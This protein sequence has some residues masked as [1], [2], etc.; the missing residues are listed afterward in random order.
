MSGSDNKESVDIQIGGGVTGNSDDDC[1]QVFE[2]PCVAPGRVERHLSPL[3]FAAATR[4]SNVAVDPEDD[5][6]WMVERSVGAVHKTGIVIEKQWFWSPRLLSLT[7]GRKGEPRKNLVLRY[8]RADLARGVL[9][10]IA[11][12]EKDPQGRF[13]EI[14][15]CGRREEAM[16]DLDITTF[17]A[18]RSAYV[19]EI[20]AKRR[21][22][23]DQYIALEAGTEALN[24]LGQQL[25]TRERNQRR[26]RLQA[27][28]SAPIWASEEDRRRMEAEEENE[29][30]AGAL[31]G[32]GRRSADP[33][34]MSEEEPAALAPSTAT[35]AASATAKGNARGKPKRKAAPA[36]PSG[37]EDVLG[38]RTGFSPGDQH[39]DGDE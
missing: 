36:S 34:S 29:T 14:L 10:E 13:R 38:G 22:L 15:R 24:A 37:L 11:I 25:I 3:D 19:R 1:L 17:L 4:E 20:V 21:L 27:I 5:G 26:K 8:N 35:P 7:T 18:E 33:D 39:T 31:S 23:E 6:L 32:T 2:Q 12:G 16:Q 9:R 30:W 28:T